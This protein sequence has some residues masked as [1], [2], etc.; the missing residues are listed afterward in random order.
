MRP[1]ATLL[2]I[3]DG[4]TGIE[5]LMGRR[6]A[7]APFA[8][9]AY[10]FP[11]GVVDL[12][13]GD[14]RAVSAAAG[15]R[16]PWKVAAIRETFEETGALV[17]VAP[18]LDTA[19]GGFWATVDGRHPVLDLDQLR[20]LSTWVTPSFVP[21]RYD[22]KFFLTCADV[23]PVSADGVEFVDVRWVDPS[24]AVA[25]GGSFPLIS[26]TRAHLEWLTRFPTAADAWEG[27]RLGRHAD[28][29]DQEQVEGVRPDGLDRA[30]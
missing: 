5:V 22:T 11:G 6:S 15:R 25:A 24:R 16:D 26:P 1:A 10:V 2:V 3:R 17:A 23:G 30:L 4:G 20:Y 12:S 8:P 29:I 19:G 7:A 13:D 27:A 9:D 21:R 18:V 14:E 28:V